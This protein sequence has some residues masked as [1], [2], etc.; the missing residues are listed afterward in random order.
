[1]RIEIVT[2]S[3]NRGFPAACNQGLKAAKGDYLVLLNN[4]AVVTDAWLDQ[5]TA[6]ADADPD[7]GLVG[8]MTNHAPPP[9]LV[10]N[11]PYDDLA[12][13]ERFAAR[14][15]TEQRGR[16]FAVNKLSGFCVLM[17]RSVYETVGAL[18]ERFGLGCFDDDDLALRTRKAGF[19]LAVARDL[20]VHHFGGRT[21]VGA[22]ID[23][24]A[25][26]AE[27]QAKYVAKWGDAAVAGQKLIVLTPWKPRPAKPTGKRPKV[28]LTMI[29][30]NEEKNL[31]ACLESARGL[32]DEI[33]VVDT[34]STD[35]TVEIARS[36]EAR[37]FDFVWVDDFAA[38]R[39]A[40]LAR[41]TGDYAFWLDADDVLEPPQ[42]E[43]CAT[44]SARSGST[45][46]PPSSSA[47]PATPTRSA[48]AAR[49]SSITSDSSPSARRSAGPTASTSRSCPPCVARGCRCAGPTS[50]SATPATPIRPSAAASSTATPRSS[51]AS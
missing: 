44:C 3:E 33:V 14:L 30:R 26:L 34:G 39:N 32:F 10:P 19:S 17:K 1:M 50:S 18:D 42:R 35:A 47:A 5:L 4:D 37:V 16:W 21:F 25:L 2:N 41:A 49:P 9:Q 40:A 13:M 6:L 20:F 12:A 23:L 27:N 46:R 29:V 15:R 48:A 22:G 28:S 11:V 45:T 7:I 31:P 24:N 43:R 38:A 8:P 36:F 51:K